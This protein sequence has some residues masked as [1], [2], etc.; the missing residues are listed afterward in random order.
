MILDALV[1]MG[2]IVFGNAAAAKA[3]RPPFGMVIKRLLCSRIYLQYLWTRQRKI[4]RLVTDIRGGAAQLPFYVLDVLTDPRAAMGLPERRPIIS[5]TKG[6]TV[7]EL[8]WKDYIL[9]G[10]GMDE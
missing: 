3:M 6:T 5:T 7:Q 10:L 8:T 2:R 9:I 1:L 4:N